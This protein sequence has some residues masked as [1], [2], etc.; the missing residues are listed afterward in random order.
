[1]NTALEDAGFREDDSFGV[2]S[3]CVLI[4]GPEENSWGA[5]ANPCRS[6]NAMVLCAAQSESPREEPHAKYRVRDPR[7]IGR[8]GKVAGETDLREEIV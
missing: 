2:E 7:E 4:Q 5:S 3:T 8:A 6:R 1:M